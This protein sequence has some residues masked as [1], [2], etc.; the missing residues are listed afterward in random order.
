M[1]D[2]LRI[3]E[4]LVDRL[5]P[6]S[7]LV[8]GDDRIVQRLALRLPRSDGRLPYEAGGRGMGRDGGGEDVTA[9][10]VVRSPIPRTC[11]HSQSGV[12]MMSASKLNS[13]IS[14]SRITMS[15]P[16][17]IPPSARG[18]RWRSRGALRR[19]RTSACPDASARSAATCA[20]R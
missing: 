18:R 7:D 9:P 6:L 4:L 11:S 16:E 8:F 20:T 10:P 15:A 13:R 3:V 14:S 19:W 17:S 5:D 2:C 1:G 12:D